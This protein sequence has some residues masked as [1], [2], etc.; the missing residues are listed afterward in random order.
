M[1]AMIGTRSAATAMHA[2]TAFVCAVF[3]AADS[4]ALTSTGLSVDAGADGSNDA[5]GVPEAAADPVGGG[6][7]AAP[8]VP[9]APVA[10][11]GAVDEVTAPEDGVEV[12]PVAEGCGG[13]SGTPVGLGPGETAGVASPMRD[14][15]AMR[16]C[17]CSSRSGPSN[18]TRA[19]AAVNARSYWAIN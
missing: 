2:A 14:A 9:E 17:R 12:A 1:A 10:P 19:G 7:A 8:V 13:G 4:C 6:G 11:A 18:A 5:A 15:S 16:C 3:S